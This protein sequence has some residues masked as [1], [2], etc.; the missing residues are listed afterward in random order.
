MLL[1]KLFSG[2]NS[3]FGC[4]NQ[5]LFFGVIINY[6]HI[7]CLGFFYDLKKIGI[8]FLEFCSNRMIVK[9]LKMSLF[10]KV[11]T[12]GNKSTIKMGRL[13]GTFAAYLQWSHKG[14]ACARKSQ[15]DLADPLY[16]HQP[17][18][19]VNLL[20][21]PWYCFLNIN[22]F[23]FKLSESFGIFSKLPQMFT[24]HTVSLASLSG[25]QQQLTIVFKNFDFCSL[26]SLGF[27]GPWSILCC[28]F[29]KVW[30]AA[31]EGQ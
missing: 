29:K 8:C 27:Q 24:N 21:I 25:S 16:L 9:T 23:H 5:S 28:S 3:D 11:F 13:K 1:L 14:T 4:G 30:I 6:C 31:G 15:F 7:L 2:L 10:I 18:F 17:F 20:I 22:Y 12:Y 19:K 26:I